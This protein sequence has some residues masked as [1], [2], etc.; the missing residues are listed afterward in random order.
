M[1]LEWYWIQNL[2]AETHYF[3]G[4]HNPYCP[5]HGPL[6]TCWAIFFILPML[7]W[8]SIHLL[9]TLLLPASSIS[10]WTTHSS[11]NTKI[12]FPSSVVTENPLFTVVGW[13]IF[14]PF[15]H[16]FTF[17]SLYSSPL[18]SPLTFLW[19][20]RRIDKPRWLW[21][22][23]A[24]AWIQCSDDCNTV[25]YSQKCKLVVACSRFKLMPQCLCWY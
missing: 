23:P 20:H 12:H 17:C 6:P 7:L 1:S 24:F 3:K 15:A 5:S 10:K 4:I 13:A 16:V 25:C 21:P 8:S 14:S 19:S 22:F 18:F 2:S 11:R 9:S